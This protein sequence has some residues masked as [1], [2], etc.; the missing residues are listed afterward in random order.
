MCI[1]YDRD[2]LIIIIAVF[3]P[4]IIPTAGPTTISII[5]IITSIALLSLCYNLL[6]FAD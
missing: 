4:A 1:S 5:I 6:R 3:I 2:Y